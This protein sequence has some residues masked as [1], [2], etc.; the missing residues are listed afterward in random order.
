MISS[1]SNQPIVRI[2]DVHQ[3]F[4]AVKVLRGI[5]LSVASGQAV[6]VIGPSGS[7]K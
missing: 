5:S 4:G 3:S 6:C 7:G 2:H 1:P